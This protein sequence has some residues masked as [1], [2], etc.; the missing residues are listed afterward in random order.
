MIAIFTGGIMLALSLNFYGQTYFNDNYKN[1]NLVMLMGTTGQLLAAL[2][3]VK[4]VLKKKLDFIFF[5]IEGLAKNI[6]LG[7]FLGFLQISIYVLLDMGRGALGFQGINLGNLNLIF[8]AY[9]IAFFIQSTSEEVLV[10][11]ILTRVLYNKY[12]RRLAILLPAIFF[13]LLHLGNEGV[14][15]LSTLNT[16][17]V[18]IFFAKLLFYSEN[19]MLT[20]G[21]HAGW[22]FSMAMIYG[23]NV[24]GFSGFDS[25]LNFKILNY[26]LYDKTYGPEGSILV[27]FI[28]IIS[29]L[30][31]FYLEKRK[32]DK[33]GR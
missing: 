7:L 6:G 23:L 11:G 20:S 33:N 21:V 13:G 10:R 14:T 30:I 9:F 1:A 18:G 2:I 25:L 3:F 15:I 27:T 24:S 5:K 16:I 8:L 29:I 26:N 12:G 19:I 32:R 4:Y 28:E 22:N 17:L 31:I